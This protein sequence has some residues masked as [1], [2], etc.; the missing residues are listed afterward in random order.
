M[1]TLKCVVFLALLCATAVRSGAA[2]GG[3]K[4]D[5]LLEEASKKTNLTAPGSTAFHLKLAATETRRND[6]QYQAEI[7]MW[8]AAPDKWR[9]EIKSPAFSQTAVQN[10]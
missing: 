7:E 4:F 1:R 8:W 2:D 3:K 6:P 10:G 9:R 5:K